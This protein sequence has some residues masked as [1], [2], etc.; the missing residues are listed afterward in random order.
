MPA[1]TGH[2]AIKHSVVEVDRRRFRYFGEK[3]VP[4]MLVAM[5]ATL[6]LKRRLRF[7]IH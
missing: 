4:K 7:A 6:A 3:S 2:S 5:G 1:T